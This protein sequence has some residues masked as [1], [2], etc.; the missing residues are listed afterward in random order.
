MNWTARTII[1]V[2]VESVSSG[3]SS[4]VELRLGRLNGRLKRGSEQ[5]DVSVLRCVPQT[6]N[7]FTELHEKGRKASKSQHRNSFLTTTNFLV[8]FVVST[9]ELF[10]EMQLCVESQSL[11]GCDRKYTGLK[12][13]YE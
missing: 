12:A 3:S 1:T 7:W 9:P 11:S 13:F 6:S 10:D 5:H 8:Y 2:F 4:A